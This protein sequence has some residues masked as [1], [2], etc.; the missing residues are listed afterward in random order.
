MQYCSTRF[1]AFGCRCVFFRFPQLSFKTS[2]REFPCLCC[3]R[4]WPGQSMATTKKPDS[5]RAGANLDSDDRLWKY[6]LLALRYYQEN[7]IMKYWLNEICKIRNLETGSWVVFV[8]TETCDAVG[9]LLEE[10]KV[11]SILK[12]LQ[13][14]KVQYS[15]YRTFFDFN[16]HIILVECLHVKLHFASGSKRMNFMFQKDVVPRCSRKLLP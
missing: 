13:H 5:A 14:A 11:H 15:C 4:P 7:T 16:I 1:I 2:S 12:V 9:W 10:V 8:P 3:D 6:R